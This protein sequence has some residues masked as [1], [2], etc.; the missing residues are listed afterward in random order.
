MIEFSICNKTGQKSNEHRAT[1]RKDRIGAK[2]AI[3]INET[4]RQFVTFPILKASHSFRVCLIEC[5]LSLS[6]TMLVYN[7][8]WHKLDKTEFSSFNGIAKLTGHFAKQIFLMRQYEKLL[9]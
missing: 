4:K 8:P 3:A 1:E 7:K 9:N 2:E 6:A 5:I